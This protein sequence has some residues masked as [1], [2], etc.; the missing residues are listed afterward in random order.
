MSDIL[1]LVTDFDQGSAFG[2]EVIE[3]QIIEP[4][5]IDDDRKRDAYLA[6]YQGLI[7]QVANACLQTVVEVSRGVEGRTFRSL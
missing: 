7:F 3:N 4:E 2:D 5:E 1:F 6:R